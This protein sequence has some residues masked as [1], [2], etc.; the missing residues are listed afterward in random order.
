MEFDCT[1]LVNHK[2]FYPDHRWHAAW[3]KNNVNWPV[4]TGS[5]QAALFLFFLLLVLRSLFLR[6]WRIIEVAPLPLAGRPG[7]HYLGLFDLAFAG[8]R[9]P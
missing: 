8:F 7:C 5:E 4:V 3:I 9:L 6:R 1:G 2:E